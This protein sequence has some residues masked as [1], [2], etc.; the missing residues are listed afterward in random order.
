MKNQLYEQEWE[1]KNVNNRIKDKDEQIK[2][3]TKKLHETDILYNEASKKLHHLEQEK[4]AGRLDYDS[5]RKILTERISVLDAQFCNEVDLR[6]HWQNQY[7]QEN[8]SL[9][10]ANIQITE[11]LNRVHEMGAKLTHLETE[12]ENIRIVNYGLSQSKKQL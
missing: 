3:T 10:K 8:H 6:K 11:F 4:K 9:S 7:E 2:K 12:L 1:V 5:Q